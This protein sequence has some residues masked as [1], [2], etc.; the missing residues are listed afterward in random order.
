MQAMVVV[1]ATIAA[2]FCAAPNAAYADTTAVKRYIMRY[3][4]KQLPANAMELPWSAFK[5][6][7]DTYTEILSPE[8]MQQFT[9]RIR[10]VSSGRIGVT[11]RRHR[12]G[13]EIV[14]VVPESPAY[15]AGLLPGDVM[16][17]SNDTSLVW[18]DVHDVGNIVR[19][20]SGTPVLIDV[21][22]DGVCWRTAVLRADLHEDAVFCT[23]FGRT[24][25]VR[26]TQFDEGLTEQFVQQTASVN[27]ATID[28]VLFDLRDN[29]GGRVDEALSM[30]S[31]FVP[32]YDTLLGT[33][34]QEE[35]EYELSEGLSRWRDERTYIILQNAESAS[36]SELFAGAMA[37]RCSAMVVGTTSYGKGRIQRVFSA[38]A[39]KET[40][41][42][43]IGGFK[44]TTATYLAG[45]TLPVD[46]IGVTPHVVADFPKDTSGQIPATL[47]VPV[48]RMQ[49]R[50]PT[51]QDFDSIDNLGYGSIAG[52]VWTDRAAAYQAYRTLMA[53]RHM[54]PT[55][56]WVCTA[57]HDDVTTAYSRKEEVAIRRLLS[58]V[59]AGDVPDSVLRI[60][61]V[62]RLLDYLQ[63][64]ATVI[65]Y[66]KRDEHEDLSKP[67]TDDMGIAL[68]TLRGAVYVTGV[69]PSSAAYAAGLCIGDR[70]VSINGRLLATGID[71][72]RRD[73][74]RAGKKGGRVDLVLRRG[75]M[76]HRVVMQAA[77]R[78]VGMPQTLLQDGV[79]SIAVD[80]FGTSAVAATAFTRSVKRLVDAGAHTLVIDLR[81]SFA[82][83]LESTLDI[84][85]LFAKKGDTLARTWQ[86]GTVAQTTIAKGNG[87][88]R[89]MPV[90]ICVD[91]A[92]SGAAEFFA[93]SMQRNRYATIVGNITKGAMVEDRVVHLAGNVGMRYTLRRFA[94]R[95][96]D[97]VQPDV[98]LD[99][100]AP[101]VQ[102]VR[103]VAV[104]LDPVDITMMRQ[105]VT[106]V[107]DEA[108]TDVMRRL[109]GAAR[110]ADAATIAAAAYGNAAR[111]YNL[112]S[113]IQRILQSTA[114]I[115]RR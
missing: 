64:R 78:D 11:K 65:P 110:D 109:R 9:D 44:I 36:A 83:G 50:Y 71:W 54:L 67:I 85:A 15:W 111:L 47:D 8:S 112:M 58:T 97:R 27:P 4:Y 29:P 55:P 98:V 61:P 21:M 74:R 25:A 84:L 68:D 41:D 39:V 48:L 72:A 6:Y 108:M 62:E 100:P 49:V 60:E 89:R 24:L 43:R 101:D 28:T 37:V 87:V 19:G 96:D 26:I 12:M 94:P 90:I 69:H 38:D 105:R 63:H 115:T 57:N 104:T 22:R 99:M 75:S 45:G 59:Y 52:L 33:Q 23:V 73:V 30:L 17:A 53:V 7:V 113:A 66:D 14:R 35:T 56:V 16:V 70:I 82:G 88:Y 34:H 32:L 102:R 51:Q 46:D 81:G 80:R 13:W 86:G 106:T 20:P 93:A 103:D 18:A 107:T 5:T 3:Y 42:K 1:A 2:L 92:T 79:G 114:P 95:A 76:M 31:Q 91:T 77:A 40:L 10:G